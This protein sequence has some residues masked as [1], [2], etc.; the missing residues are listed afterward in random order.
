MSGN[1]KRL[2]K[3]LFD[4]AR[5]AYVPAH[6]QEY[7]GLKRRMEKG[8]GEAEDQQPQELEAY[9]ERNKSDEAQT[10]AAIFKKSVGSTV[11]EKFDS[12]IHTIG[13]VLSG[14]EIE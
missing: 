8:G 7:R 1:A 11:G 2:L 9:F 12:F 10:V 13:D 6:L 5:A 4:R 14:Q 3:H